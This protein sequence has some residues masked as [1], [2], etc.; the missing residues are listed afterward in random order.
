MTDVNA[1]MDAHLADRSPVAPRPPGVLGDRRLQRSPRV[2]W[3]SARLWRRA[4]FAGLDALASRLMTFGEYYRHI[5]CPF[6]LVFTHAIVGF[7][8][9]SG[10]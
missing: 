1:T 3:V 7:V 8:D 9:K 2:G 10:T 5:A 6:E 4:H